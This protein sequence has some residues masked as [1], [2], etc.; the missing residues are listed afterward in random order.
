M[1]IYFNILIIYL[2]IITALKFYLKKPDADLY[3]GRPGESVFFT[4]FDKA[5]IFE[6]QKSGHLN[7]DYIVVTTKDNKIWDISGGGTRLLF[8]HNHGGANQRFTMIERESGK[9][10]ILAN[11]F[12]DCVTY[13]T[14]ISKFDKMPCKEGDPAQDFN[15]VAYETD[16][17]NTGDTVPVSKHQL[18]ALKRAALN[19]PEIREEMGAEAIAELGETTQQSQSRLMEGSYLF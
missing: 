9:V 2:Y 4:E 1:S 18:E 13:I 3:V 8:W 19:C 5:D 17:E 11:N 12:K 10:N 7:Q 15:F 14:S 16:A 6:L